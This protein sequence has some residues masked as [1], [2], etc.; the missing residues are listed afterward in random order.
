M[1]K[2]IDHVH[3]LYLSFSDVPG[4]V[5]SGIQLVRM[6][7]YTLWSR[8]MKLNLLTKN[9]LGMILKKKQ[10]DRCNAMVISWIVSNVSK[11]LVS[12]ILF[13]SNATLVWSN[14][15]E[16]FDKDEFESI[17]PS[18]SCEYTKSKKYVDSMGR[19]QLLQF[20][21]GLNDSYGQARSQILMMNPPPSVNQCY[22]TIVQDESQR[23]LSGD[24]YGGGES[25]DPTALLTNRSGGYTFGGPGS[26]GRGGRGH[27]QVQ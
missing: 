5:R 4:A 11:E 23:A 24:C 8:T 3:P 27:G 17:M 7:N 22:A 6:E 12:G 19:Q 14:L 26:R 21:I 9:K 16:R 20:L 18:S 10:W 25:I 2:K 13:R 1:A 15:K